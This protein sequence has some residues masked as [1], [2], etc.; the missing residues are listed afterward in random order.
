MEMD[1]KHF[2]E[3]RSAENNPQLRSFVK[4]N[5]PGIIICFVFESSYAQKKRQYVSETME[6][7]DRVAEMLEQTAAEIRRLRK[8]H[9]NRG[10]DQ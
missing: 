6:A 10:A 2:A 1:S 7:P 4:M 8:A 9:M 3:F 5:G